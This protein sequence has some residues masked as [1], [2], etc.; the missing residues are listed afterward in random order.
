[1]ALTKRSSSSIVA[2][3]SNALTLTRGCMISATRVS[4]KSSTPSIISPSL[5][6]MP[7]LSLAP[8]MISRSSSSLTASALPSFLI[9]PTN[10]SVFFDRPAKPM[11]TGPRIFVMMLMGGAS[12]RA[13][14]SAL[15]TPMALGSS[16]PKKSVPAVSI[17]VA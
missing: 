5:V 12:S 3:R 8:P 1:M 13:V 14:R 4:C 9:N 11:A 15:L 6:S 2:F 7:P 16:S 17:A 10:F